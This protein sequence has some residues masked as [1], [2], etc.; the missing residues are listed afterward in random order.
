MKR[1][2]TLVDSLF[3]GARDCS[4]PTQDPQDA[5]QQ[6][7]PTRTASAS[8]SQD[9]QNMFLSASELSVDAKGKRPS[10]LGAVLIA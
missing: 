5:D 4:H 8:G 7:D 3:H 9:E 1:D 6:A 2:K 10:R